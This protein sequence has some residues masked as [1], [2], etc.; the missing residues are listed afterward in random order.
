M[1]QSVGLPTIF[2]VM[3]HAQTEW[4][5]QKRIQGQKDSRLT[6]KGAVWA[7]EWGEFFQGQKWSQ[8]IAS[9][10]GR[11]R[12]TVDHINAFL[13]LPTRFTRL[14]REQDWGL[15]TGHTLLD[16]KRKYGADLFEQVQKGWEF[17]PPGGE[18]RTSVYLRA[19]Q[20][21]LETAKQYSGQ[22][23]LVV[24]HEGVLKALIYHLSGR[25][26]LPHEPTL[27]KKAYIHTLSSAHGSLALEAVNFAN[28]TVSPGNPP[29]IGHDIEV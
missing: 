7:R 5:V 1:N 13:D 24:C 17:C 15:W 28:P 29:F 8:I 16:V 9:D 22:R 25:L 6:K 4:N 26:F 27:I 18:S 14:L 2:G 21:L 3:R 19:S 23:V 12:E 10:L 20:A 11:A